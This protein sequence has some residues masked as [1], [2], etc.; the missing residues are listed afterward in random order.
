MEFSETSLNG[1][2]VV[3]LKRIEDE[4][5]FFARAWCR[6]EFV[7]HGLEPEWLN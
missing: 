5:G 6:E 7:Q 2:Y 1:A 3:Q 4:R